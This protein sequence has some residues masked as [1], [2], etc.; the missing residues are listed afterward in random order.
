MSKKDES[1]ILSD[2]RQARC[3]GLLDSRERI[4]AWVKTRQT[5]SATAADSVHRRLRQQLNLRFC[6]CLST[7][8]GSQSPQQ[9]YT[10]QQHR[11]RCCRTTTAPPYGASQ[12]RPADFYVCSISRPKSPVDPP[13]NIYLQR[14]LLQLYILSIL[15][16]RHAARCMVGYLEAFELR[17]S[18]RD[19]CRALRVGVARRWPVPEEELVV[20][21]FHG[22]GPSTGAAHAPAAAFLSYQDVWRARA[23]GIDGLRHGLHRLYARTSR[24]AKFARPTAVCCARKSLFSCYRCC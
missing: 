14:R 24:T 1:L 9:L 10:Q 11:F 12:L 5:S 21:N 20:N 7:A 16:K 23:R 4:E 18:R 6:C 13:E 22:P 15:Q 3:S 19:P 17:S 8:L 2:Q